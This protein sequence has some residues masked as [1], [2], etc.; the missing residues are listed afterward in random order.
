M[1]FPVALPECCR[2][3]GKR[4]AE[5]AAPSGGSADLSTVCRRSDANERG[6]CRRQAI[7]VLG[8]DDTAG[9][10]HS[11]EARIKGG[12]ADAAGGTQ[13]AEGAGPIS[14]GKR[15]DDALVDRRGDRFRHWLLV[16]LDGLESERVGMLSECE[17][18]V[19]DGGGGA[20]LGSENDVVSA[21]AT[22]IKIGITPGV[23][24]G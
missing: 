6:L 2:G 4:E 10:G 23:E 15:G 13:L 8:F 17:G 12:G 24:L 7:T 20:V 18:K 16:R 1:D 3:V 19:G 14:I 9:I 5:E 11:R 22:E 21:V